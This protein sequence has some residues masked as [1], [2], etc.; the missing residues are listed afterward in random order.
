[1]RSVYPACVRN[2]PQGGQTAADRAKDTTTCVPEEISSCRCEESGRNR[3]GT[4]R[5]DEEVS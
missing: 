3:R 1:M 4:G 5:R 2:G